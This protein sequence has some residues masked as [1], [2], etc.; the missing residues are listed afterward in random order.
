MNCVWQTNK[1][2]KIV[3]VWQHSSLCWL[4][5]YHIFQM[6]D[7]HT[8]TQQMEWSEEEKKRWKILLN[9]C[10]SVCLTRR[11]QH[12]Q[13]ILFKYVTKPARNHPHT[14]PSLYRLTNATRT[15]RK[16][17]IQS[18]LS[19]LSDT[20]TNYDGCYVRCFVV[21]HFQHNHRNRYTT[22]AFVSNVIYSILF[23]LLWFWFY[24][25]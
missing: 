2:T 6:P 24:C 17:N 14:L 1:Q 9:I 10:V 8:H 20:H 11:F 4:Y 12:W 15:N 3:N 16:I 23:W 22:D 25:V 19:W 18:I 21:P 7:T 5:F 13:K